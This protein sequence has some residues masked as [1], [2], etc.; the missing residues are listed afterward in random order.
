MARRYMTRQPAAHCMT[1]RGR[2]VLLGVSAIAVVTTGCSPAPSPAPP[3]IT[4]PPVAADVL[5]W[6]DLVWSVAEGVADTDADPDPSA[7]AQVVSVT[8]GPE[9]FVAVGFQE[10]GPHRDGRIWYSADGTTWHRVGEQDEFDAVELLDVAPSPEGFVALGIGNLGAAVERPHAA[11]FT[12]SDGRSWLRIA[13]V[14]GSEDTYPESLTGGP[15]GVVAA[16][17]DVDGA[18]VVWRSVDGQTFE[19]VA[20]ETTDGAVHG[21]VDPE[22]VADGY[23]ALG[24]MSEP[25]IFMRSTD[26]ERWEPT[27]IEVAE[28]MVATE[29]VP[30]KWGNVVRGIWAPGCTGMA[31]CGGETIAW[32]SRDGSVWVRLPA[33]DSPIATGVSL[34][35]GAGQHGLLAIDG[36]NAWESPDGWA[37]RPL[38][39]P[40]DGSMLVSDAVVRGNVIVAVGATYTADAISEPAIIVAK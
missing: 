24:S 35:V 31:A 33:A 7:G 15:D 23:V 18:S 13:G 2:L 17:S 29:L 22:A 34:V 27:P 38:P 40:G 26:A 25:P 10:R 11:F 5:P 12:S 39:E 36:A 1:M 14:P 6:P 9:G 32:W 19:R 30:G 21:I 20:I 16:G 37:W 4:P 3:S 8:A 28:D